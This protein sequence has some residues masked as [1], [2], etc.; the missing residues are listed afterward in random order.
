LK[1]YGLSLYIGESL[2]ARLCGW[3]QRWGCCTQSHPLFA[4]GLSRHSTL[5]GIRQSARF[6]GS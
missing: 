5:T 4:I 3:P 6:I 2:A 1:D